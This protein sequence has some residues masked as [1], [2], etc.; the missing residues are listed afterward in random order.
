MVVR[1]VHNSLSCHFLESE[2]TAQQSM[3]LIFRHLKPT[4]MGEKLHLGAM[5]VVHKSLVHLFLEH[6]KTA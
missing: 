3:S 2:R 6:E 1:K 4:F 5:R